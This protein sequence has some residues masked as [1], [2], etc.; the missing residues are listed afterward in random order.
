MMGRTDRI[1][2]R[3]G[4]LECGVG[5]GWLCDRATVWSILIA[6]IYLWDHSEVERFCVFASFMEGYISH[7]N[8]DS[9]FFFFL[10]NNRPKER[11]SHVLTLFSS[12]FSF[13]FF[14][15]LFSIPKLQMNATPPAAIGS[16]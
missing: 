2:M 1:W 3:E 14:T 10:E 7:R 15:V 8:D 13:F 6:S 16:T 9:C 4:G 12:D 11:F 5:S